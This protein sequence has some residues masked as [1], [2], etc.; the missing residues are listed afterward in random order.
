MTHDGK[1][2]TTTESAPQSGTNNASLEQSKAEHAKS[3]S[4]EDAR[5]PFPERSESTEMGG[6]GPNETMNKI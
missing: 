2:P 6:T 1:R 4:R 5:N 3:G